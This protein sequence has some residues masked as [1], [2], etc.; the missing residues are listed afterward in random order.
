VYFWES[1]EF[2]FQSLHYLP[3]IVTNLDQGPFQYPVS[4]ILNGKDSFHNNMFHYLRGMGFALSE[5][6]NTHFHSMI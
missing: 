5:R 6:G 2:S 3:S 4:V 1:A